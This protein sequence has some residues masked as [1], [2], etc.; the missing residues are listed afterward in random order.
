LS[1]CRCRGEERASRVSQEHE[2]QRARLDRLLGHLRDA[3]R[4]SA[5]IA[6]ELQVLLR[7]LIEDMNQEE[8]TV[9]NENLLRDD[10]ISI[11]MEAG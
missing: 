11:S 1:V 3:S 9:L 6:E 10:P 2:E 7:D 5:E 4:P 8:A